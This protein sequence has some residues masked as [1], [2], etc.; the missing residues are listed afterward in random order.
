MN[1]E[2]KAWAETEGTE[3][4]AL[5]LWSGPYVVQAG[6]PNET[7]VAEVGA[8][9][10]LV[11]GSGASADLRVR[12]RGVSARHCV[13]E[14][15]DGVLHLEDLDSKNGLF[16]GG[17]RVRAGMFPGAGGA[18]VVGGASVSI[19]PALCAPEPRA[20][21]VPGLVGR[22][23]AMVGVR[24]LIHRY[25]KLRRPVLIQGESGTGK[26]VVARALH[27]VS[28]REGD[29]VAVN[30]GAIAESLADAE[31]F[32]HR[33]G[34]FTG[35]VVSREGAFEQAHGGTIFLDEV[36]EL[37]ANMQVRLLRVVEDGVVRPVGGKA[38]QVDSRVV[39]ASWALLRDRVAAGQF[40][41][42][43]FHRLSTLQIELPPLRERK[44]D[45]A[46]LARHLLARFEGELGARRLSSA[47]LGRLVAHGWPGNVRELSSVLYRAAVAIDRETID[48]VTLRES[49]PDVKGADA[50]PLSGHNVL[51][52]LER[53]GGNVSRAAR[54]ARLPRPTIRTWVNKARREAA[55]AAE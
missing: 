43:L 29:F 52:L 14:V 2:T 7:A 55:A 13:L 26:D 1:S 38:T 47:A 30:V 34:A 49:L 3:E 8:G 36:A 53:C 54:A 46:D 21:A 37:P 35:A 19:E 27:D 5:P 15:R 9:E 28:E 48:E 16:L 44:S 17:A 39:S 45:I 23:R 42:D 6:G 18:F 11:I 10:R 4:L 24:H 25:A 20:R 50:K 51:E 40:R 12:E 31:L 22:S 32:G 33:R 41:A